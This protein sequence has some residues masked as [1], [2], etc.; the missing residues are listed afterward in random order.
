MST[1]HT[2]PPRTRPVL[3][4]KEGNQDYVESEIRVFMWVRLLK[5]LPG[6]EDALSKLLFWLAGEMGLAV[7]RRAQFLG[8]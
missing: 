5:D 4:G 1:P 7:G 8:V 6:L 3:E 2:E